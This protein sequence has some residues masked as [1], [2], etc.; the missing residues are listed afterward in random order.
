MWN[1]LVKHLS[2]LL[3]LHNS[4]TS[5]QYLLNLNRP[6]PCM[7]IEL[8]A[9]LTTLAGIVACVFQLSLYTIIFAF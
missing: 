3:K 4:I 9:I 2:L 8:S 5:G 1:Q 6:M 7:G